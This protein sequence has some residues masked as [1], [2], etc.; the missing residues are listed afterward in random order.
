M[1]RKG[2]KHSR[3]GMGAFEMDVSDGAFAGL[4]SL[5]ADVGAV[6]KESLMGGKDLLIMAA[7]ATV[8]LAG[9]D[10]VLKRLPIPW[11]KIPVIRDR[12]WIGR[13]LVQ[14]TLAMAAGF[15]APRI[16]QP[17]L[18]GAVVGVGAGAMVGA[19]LTAVSNLAPGMVQ[20]YLPNYASA[21]MAGLGDSFSPRRM[22]NGTVIDGDL[23]AQAQLEGMGAVGVE[24]VQPGAYSLAGI[25]YSL[26]TMDA[27]HA[28]TLS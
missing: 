1:A 25:G 14:A 7:G 2:R 28:A 17:E 20:S 6:V 21:G 11:E 15:A 24:E 19:V 27:Q 12:P 10:M 26:P 3:R 22:L 5:G 8:G 23:Q 9:S 16:S 18:R 4:G 13:A